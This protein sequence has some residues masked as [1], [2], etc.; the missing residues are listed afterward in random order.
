MSD[1]IHWLK[2]GEGQVTSLRRQPKGH[3]WTWGA[4]WCLQGILREENG[5][6]SL[7]RLCFKWCLTCTVTGNKEVK[8]FPLSLPSLFGAQFSSF[9]EHWVGSNDHQLLPSSSDLYTTEFLLA[10]SWICYCLGCKPFKNSLQKACV[11]STDH[12]KL[13]STKMFLRRHWICFIMAS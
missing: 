4:W 5:K 2:G 6:A 12:S 3:E 7:R 10:M 9:V 13:V 11:L 1:N 8:E